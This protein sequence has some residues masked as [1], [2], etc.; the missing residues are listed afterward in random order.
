MK[1]KFASILDKKM[2]DF[3]DEVAQK[4]KGEFNGGPISSEKVASRAGPEVRAKLNTSYHFQHS[5]TSLFRIGR[6]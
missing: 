5:Q 4:P 3:A 2:S 6:L 1:G